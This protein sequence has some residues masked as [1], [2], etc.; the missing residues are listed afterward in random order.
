MDA[1]FTRFQPA[2]EG[3]FCFDNATHFSDRDDVERRVDDVRG[4]NTGSFRAGST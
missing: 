2:D 1:P 4:Q 3:K